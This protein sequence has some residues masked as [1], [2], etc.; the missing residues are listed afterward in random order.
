MFIEGMTPIYVLQAEIPPV[1]VLVFV[2]AIPLMLVLTAAWYLYRYKRQKAAYT[3]RIETVIEA[4]APITSLTKENQEPVEDIFAEL[5]WS[6]AKNRWQAIRRESE[7]RFGGR[8]LPPL[9]LY[10]NPETLLP[11]SLLNLLSQ[12]P[13]ILVFSIGLLAATL[14][15]I[16]LKTF[17]SQFFPGLALIPLSVGCIAGLILYNV[18]RETGKSLEQACQNLQ[19]EIARVIPVYTSHSGTA[20][21]IDELVS[22]E[23]KLQSGIEE[24]TKTS[25]AMADSDFSRGICQSVRQIMTEEVAPPLVEASQTLGQLAQ[26][27]DQRQMT[28]MEKLSREFSQ[29]LT[30]DIQQQMLPFQEE[31][32]NLNRMMGRTKDFIEDSVE[33]LNSNRQQNIVLN[34][35]I[36]ESLKLMTLAKNDLANEM[37]T[38]SDNITLLSETSDKMARSYAGEEDSLNEKIKEL[39]ATGREAIQVFSHSLKQASSSLALAGQLRDEQS[40]QHEEFSIQL[41]R[42]IQELE[43]IDAGLQRATNNF[44]TESNAFVKDSLQAFDQGLAEIVERLVFTA[45]SLRDAVDT[46]PEAL[47]AVTR[48]KV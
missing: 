43:D 20:L 31:L 48:R 25:R 21:L 33:V 2:V 13:A 47:K 42:V 9:E 27:L 44:T 28:G 46:L 3:A 22:H 12:R 11:T 34:K 29:Q 36:A 4:L 5:D 45:T 30:Q 10:L 32:T 17:T 39:S 18:S 38:I 6:Q 23:N 37:T 1:M 24:F 7:S 15:F 14:S 40:K 41:S 8:W 19:R 35:E 26:S 16:Y